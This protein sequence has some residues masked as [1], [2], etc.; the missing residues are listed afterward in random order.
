LPVAPER[1][2]P[3]VNRVPAIRRPI[4]EKQDLAQS[5]RLMRDVFSKELADRSQA[6]RQALAKRLLVEAGRSSAVPADQ[7]TMLNGAIDAAS[8]GASLKLTFEAA[9]RIAESFEADAPALKLDAVTRIAAKRPPT[10]L[11]AADLPG[12]LDL[13]HKLAAA[14]DYPSALRLA[15]TLRP[16]ASDAATRDALQAAAKEVGE[17]KAAQDRLSQFIERLKT[18]PDDPAANLAVGSHH[19]FRN[20]DWERGLPMLAKSADAALSATAKADLLRLADFESQ[21]KL[22]DAWH[23]AAAKVSKEHKLAAQ[24]RAELWY[25]RALTRAAGLQRLAIQKHLKELPGSIDFEQL[26]VVVNAGTERTASS[27]NKVPRGSVVKP[28][29]PGLLVGFEYTTAGF[30]GRRIIKSIAATFLTAQGKETSRVYGTPTKGDTQIV[31]ARP[32]YAV[33]GLVADATDRCNG[34]KIIF[35]RVHGAILDAEDSYESEWIGGK[36]AATPDKLGGDG[37]P[38]VA[39]QI[40]SGSDVD[41]IGLVLTK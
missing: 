34:F 31:I 35:M 36:Q 28:S 5:R 1:T 21:A 22:G 13:V 30:K 18:A 24:E 41:T 12:V 9:D 37:R 27:G 32:G 16:L 38:V 23:T 25:T 2:K 10:P 3:D 15:T 40:L 11:T 4:P 17:L 39:A 8:E 7:F 19:C 14:E 6:G 29:S 26:A 20:R 33:G